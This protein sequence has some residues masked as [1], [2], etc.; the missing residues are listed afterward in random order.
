MLCK[1]WCAKTFPH[2]NNLQITIR[3][4]SITWIKSINIFNKWSQL[5]TYKLELRDYISEWEMSVW[6]YALKKEKKM[7]FEAIC[8]T[9]IMK[10]RVKLEVSIFRN[11]FFRPEQK[12]KLI[13]G[14]L[15]FLIVYFKKFLK[16]IHFRD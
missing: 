12:L 2:L 3:D 16:S 9:P 15:L 11:R 8:R 10:E 14:N 5:T 4:I 1:A 6:L 7:Q 13:L